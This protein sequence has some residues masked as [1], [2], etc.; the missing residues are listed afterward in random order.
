MA[1]QYH[2]QVGHGTKYK[3]LSHYRA[4]HG[5]TGHALAAGGWPGWRVPYEPLPGGFIHLHTPDPYRPPFPGGARV[6]RRHVRAAPGGGH[7][8]GGPGDDRGLHR[9]A[10]HDVGGR[11]RAAARLP[12]AGAR[13]VRP[14]R[15]RP[16]LRRDHHRVRPDREALR[17]GALE[18]LARHLLPRQGDQRRLRAAVREPPHDEDRPGVLRQRRRPGPVPRRPHLRREPGGVGGRA[19]PPSGRSSTRG[20]SRTRAR[21]ASRRWRASASCRG[22]CP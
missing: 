10:D 20:S 19:S 3:I 9:R 17:G 13:A 11:G 1:R 18:R 6:A 22:A 21:A 14:L 5:G 4:Y 2:K 8:A 16:H 7:P 12:P 15:H